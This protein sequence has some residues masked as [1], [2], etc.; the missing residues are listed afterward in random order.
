M[1]ELL[2]QN[3]N[4]E[5]YVEG[6]RTRSGKAL[7]PKGGILSVIVDAYMDGR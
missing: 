2:R 1:L 5:F 4:F 7:M 6:G 3:E